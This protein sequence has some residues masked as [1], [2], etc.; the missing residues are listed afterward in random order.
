MN[1]SLQSATRAARQWT[2]QTC[3]EFGFCTT[4]KHADTRTDNH[5]SFC[6][7]FWVC[8]C[9]CMCT[10]R[11]DLWGCRLSLLWDA[12]SADRHYALLYAVWHFPA[13][14]PS[15]HCL[16]KHF[17]WRRQPSHTQDPLCQWWDW[18]T[19]RSKEEEIMEVT[20]SC[21]WIITTGGI[22]PW[23]EL[24]VLQDGTEGGQEAQIILS[25]DTAHC[26]DMLS[27]R[28]TD[29]WS[30]RKAR[31]VGTGQDCDTWWNAINQLNKHVEDKSLTF[32][33]PLVKH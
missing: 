5:P 18:E 15:S 27:S 1:T 23:K 32:P 24:S 17:L 20:K 33:R 13:F 22:D 28:V 31:Q 11:S 7:V 4:H 16:H 25:E 26:A 14:T 8:F 3:T 12:D 2:Y 19:Q 10:R 6:T 9:V 21:V 29:R 30:L